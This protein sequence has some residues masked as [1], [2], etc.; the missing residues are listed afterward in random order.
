MD[1]I[2]LAASVI[3]LASAAAQISTAISRLRHFGEV[4]GKIY[5][6]K[7]EVSD[8]EVVLRHIGQALEDKSLAPDT[9]HGSLEQIIARTKGHLANLAKALERVANAW[10]GSKVKVISRSTIW[11]KE[12]ELFQTF[13]DDIGSVK[14]T[15]NLILGTA[16]SQHI[17]HII[18]ELQKVSVLTTK[19]GQTNE[20]TNQ[21][22]TDNHLAMS[23]RMDQQHQVLRDRIDALGK[24]FIAQHLGDAETPSSDQISSL[25]ETGA[26]AQTVRVMNSLRL[27]CRG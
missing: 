3:A 17:Q 27:P 23:I 4:P 19:S 18:L 24:L 25:S 10:K 11:L 15:L 1:P 2:S 7:N 22:L 5:A 16:N 9:A 26:N 12:K 21:G 14:A 6:L 20:F 13:R 8:L